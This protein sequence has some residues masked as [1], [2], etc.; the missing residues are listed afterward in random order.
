MTTR[1]PRFTEQDRGELLALAEYKA[2]LCPLCGQ[3][4]DICTSHEQGGPQFAA[5]YTVC[6]ATLTRLEIQRAM[7][8]GGKK[9]VPNH[10]AYLWATTIRKR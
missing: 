8:D 2:G 7:S 9:E 3:L 5:E 4:L 1:E 10:P 6:R